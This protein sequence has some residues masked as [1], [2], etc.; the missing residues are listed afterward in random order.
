MANE[1]W[2][3]YSAALERDA[4][5]AAVDEMHGAA[6]AKDEELEWGEPGALSAERP[7]LEPPPLDAMPPS[8][9]DVIELAHNR[10]TASMWACAAVA[11]GAL[12]VASMRL[13]RVRYSGFLAPLTGYFAHEAASGGSKSSVWGDLFGGLE[14]AEREQ[15]VRYPAALQR[16]EAA[17]AA[18]EQAGEEFNE[19]EPVD[20]RFL[21]RNATTPIIQQVLGTCHPI[22]AQVSDES[23]T[24]LGN[25]SNRRGADMSLE[26]IGVYTGFWS[27]KDERFERVKQKRDF[28]IRGGALGAVFL[29]Q[30][31]VVSDW[32]MAGEREGLPARFFISYDLA[33]RDEYIPPR[34]D[35]PARIV[36]FKEATKRM[37]LLADPADPP[38]S[39]HGL[40]VLPLDADADDLLHGWFNS[41]RSA[42]FKRDE[43]DDAL[44]SSMRRSHELAA[45]LAAWMWLY[46][47][48]EGDAEPAGIPLRYAEWGRTWASAY[49][50]NLGKLMAGGADDQL[51]RL[52]QGASRNA[53]RASLKG[54]VEKGDGTVTGNQIRSGRVMKEQPALRDEVLALLTR[55]HHIRPAIGRRA[56]RYEVNPALLE[57]GG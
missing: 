34:Q 9:A 24:V 21:I 8:L 53:V 52:A 43:P 18:A 6:E 32:M 51:S 29:G 14:E 49:Q 57:K 26:A 31:G 23:T 56:G 15:H 45:R 30:L 41:Q 19:P 12:S 35:A 48:Q 40:P 10:S 44:G 1:H 54:M 36:E 11:L 47:Q 27:G 55:E 42:S 22:Q 39:L 13:F 28:F 33:E 17:K 38:P 25:F 2:V 16:H 37:A 50:D 3:E 20:C 4:L 46:R 5:G 7:A